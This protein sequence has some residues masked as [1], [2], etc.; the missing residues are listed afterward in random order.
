ME[1]ST[2]RASTAGAFIFSRTRSNS[3]GWRLA[4]LLTALLLAVPILVVFSAFLSPERDIWNHLLEFVLPDLFVNT[5]WLVIGVGAGTAL[6]GVS[7]A[8]LTALYDFPG[9]GF[10]SWALLLPLAVPS[11]VTAFVSIGLLDFAGPLQTWLREIFGGQIWFLPIRSTGGVIAVM[12][13]ALYPYVYLLS[14]NA[15]LSQGKRTLEVAQS[16][17]L[18]R[19]QGFFR[20]ALPMARPWIAGGLLLVLMETLA[21]FGAVAAFNYDTF[22]TAIYKTWFGMFSLSAAA[23]LASI[24]IVMV[25]VI[26]LIEQHLRAEVR[27]TETGKA[28]RQTRFAL[29]GTRRWLASFY[30]A[31]VLSA[32]FI[33]P[34]IQL[35]MWSSEASVD[36]FDPRTLQY[37]WRSLALGGI[38]AVLTGAVA[39]VLVYANRRQTDVTTRAAIRFATFGYAVPGAVLG[40]GIFIPVAWLDAHLSVFAKTIFGI[41]ASQALQGTV[42]VMLLAYLV[43]F[44]AVSFNPLDAA[45]QRITPSTEEAARSLGL[46]SK[47]VLWR[48]HLPILRSGLFSGAILVFVDVMKE[49]PITLMTRPFGWDT[50]AVRIFEM[51]SEGQWERAAPP[52][53][54]LVLAGLLPIIWLNRHAEKC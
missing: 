34:V 39:L 44:L 31:L 32:G 1:T 27:Y 42:L 18:S 24:L 50:L 52:A 48:V 28:G 37:L 47:R 12:T 6:L 3:S 16:L 26:V 54:A 5:L 53:V 21:D 14:R 23:Q 51:T 20:A 30:A 35:L 43:R 11:Y 36:A 15:F 9:R 40:V 41:D 29:R 22:T 17:G 19:S 10:F 38:A 13:L 7:L 8:W 45:M 49:M 33:V 25:F 4:V 46:D 2:A